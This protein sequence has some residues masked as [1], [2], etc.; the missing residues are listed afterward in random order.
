MTDNRP[1]WDGPSARKTSQ[2]LVFSEAGRDSSRPR[3][4]FQN[5]FL[6]ACSAVR[7]QNLS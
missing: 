5:C 4:F 7:N 6:N 2:W 3:A 1:S